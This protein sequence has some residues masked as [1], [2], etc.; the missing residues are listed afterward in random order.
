MTAT[1]TPLSDIMTQFAHDVMHGQPPVR[2]PCGRGGLARWPLGPGRI[3]L[4]GGGPGAGK[5]ALAMQ[6]VCDAVRRHEDLRALICNVE[7]PISALLER[8]LARLSQVPLTQIQTRTVAPG[9]R[10]ALR[11]GLATIEELADRLFFAQPPFSMVRLTEA[12]A[13]HNASLILLD[14][15]QR[16]APPPGEYRDKRSATSATMESLRMLATAGAGILAVSA[17]GRARDAKG[18]TGYDALNLASFKE[19]GE[20]EYGADDAYLL[21]PAPPELGRDGRPTGT[22]AVTARHV[23][24]R[25]GEPVDLL[26]QFERRTQRFT[27]MGVPQQEDEEEDGQIT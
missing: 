23:K 21:L 1:A 26:L 18:R 17:V 6:L 7:M 15:L 13:E 14:Y 22:I 4:V 20:I 8:Q 3:V 27:E 12:A 19:T 9:D 10:A 11:R 16:I 5:T 2:W 24:A 25:Y